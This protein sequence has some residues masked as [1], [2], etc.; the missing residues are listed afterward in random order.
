MGCGWEF[1]VVFSNM[2]VRGPGPFLF[3]F[4]SCLLSFWSPGEPVLWKVGH[5]PLYH[6]KEFSL[7]YLQR[8]PGVWFP[9]R[10][11]RLGFPRL[12]SDSWPTCSMTKVRKVPSLFVGFPVCKVDM[13]IV[14]T[15]LGY[16]FSLFSFHFLSFFAV[17]IIQFQ[18]LSNL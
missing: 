10:K 12:I 9:T 4:W 7:W 11:Q 5:Q 13:M 14:A 1:W 16:C 3:F 15:P 6:F 8:H 2:V 18:R 17:A